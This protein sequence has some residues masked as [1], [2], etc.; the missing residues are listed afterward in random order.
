MFLWL[1]MV[2]PALDDFLKAELVLYRPSL[3]TRA[4]RRLPGNDDRV[5]R[6]VCGMVLRQYNCWAHPTKA[7]Y[8]STSLPL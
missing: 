7:E 5:I 8:G 4:P 3:R 2:V 6:Y 1:Y